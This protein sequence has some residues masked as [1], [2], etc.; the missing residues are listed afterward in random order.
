MNFSEKISHKLQL[1]PDKPGVYLMRDRYGRIIYIGK[2]TSLRNRVRWYFRQGTR[3]SADPK[4]R[5]LI[6]SIQDF[7]YIVVRDE[8]SAVLTEGKMIKEYRP[9]YNVAFRD[10]KRFLLLRIDPNEPYPRFNACRIKKDDTALYFGPYASTAAARAA[11]A[12]C[13]RRFGLR[14]C[15]ARIP[16]PEQYKHCLNDIIRFCSAPCMKKIQQREYRTRVE[17][18]CAFLRGE[19]QEYLQEIEAEMEQEATAMNFEKAAA[20][21]DTLWRLQEAVKQRSRGTKTLK[22]KREDAKAGLDELKGVLGLDVFPRII[23]CY[24]ISNISGTYAVGSMVCSVDGLP[25]KNRYRLFRIKTVEDIDDPGMM[26]EVIC[27]R[28]TRLQ[29]QKKSYPDLVIVDGGIT[30]LRAAQAELNRLKLTDLPLIG[31]AKRFEEIYFERKSVSKPIRLPLDSLA[32]K[33]VQHIRDE[34]HRFALTY[35]RKLRGKRI[36]ESLLD[37]VPGIGDK[38][39]QVLLNHFGSIAQL[40]KASAE[41]IAEI[42]GVGFSMAE[43]IKKNIAP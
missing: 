18:A 4:L 24:D 25:Q 9:R 36:K 21:R 14:Q 10:D 29:E 2:A 16:G 20:L 40:K 6:R 41:Q 15:V 7:D 42:S 12:F 33:V 8:A 28:F 1:L 26:A 13:E 22:T 19:K 37:E 39:K 5:G 38:R 23:E 31:L 3:K 34:A 27:R 30:Q 43:R 17:L 35:H 32:L 11:M